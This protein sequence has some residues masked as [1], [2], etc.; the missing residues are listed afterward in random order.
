MWGGGGL[1]GVWGVMQWRVPV[2]SSVFMVPLAAALSL[3]AHSS[4][5]VDVVFGFVPS[6]S[7][8]PFCLLHINLLL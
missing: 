8:F 3:K 1:G 5:T 4:A 2:I 6:P 7:V